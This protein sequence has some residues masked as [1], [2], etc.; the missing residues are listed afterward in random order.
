M[1]DQEAF[2]AWWQ[3]NQD[4]GPS[5]Q[6]GEAWNAALA[7]LRSQGE[8][9]TFI[10]E[11]DTPLGVFRTLRIGDC[12][13]RTPDRCIPVFLAPQPAVPVG[14]QPMDAKRLEFVTEGS[15]YVQWEIRPGKPKRYRMVEDGDAWGKWY[16]SARE[17]ID[18]AMLAAAPEPSK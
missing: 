14:W 4:R 15:W 2:E 11:L 16:L 12:N 17:A 3:N 10:Y 9:Y 8:P 1:T 5:T 7:W 18:A 13:G 6:H